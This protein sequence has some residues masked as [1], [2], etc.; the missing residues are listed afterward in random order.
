MFTFNC[1]VSKDCFILTLAVWCWKIDAEVWT[2]IMQTVNG[3]KVCISYLLSF[4][5]RSSGFNVETAT[6]LGMSKFCSLSVLL[7]MFVTFITYFLHVPQVPVLVFFWCS[8]SSISSSANL[9][10]VHN[11]MPFKKSKDTF[12]SYSGDWQLYSTFQFKT[13]Y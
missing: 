5:C 9:A 7:L 11:L 1:T 4:A 12:S 3:I 6:I 10:V 8:F 2:C 13:T